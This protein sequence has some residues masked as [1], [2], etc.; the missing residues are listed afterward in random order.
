MLAA[1]P[2]GAIITAVGVL[3]AAL[4]TLWNTNEGFRDAVMAI[5]EAIKGFFVAAVEVIKAAWSGIT[6]FFSAV[7][8]GIKTAFSGVTEF[9]GGVFSAAWDAIK[10]VWSGVTA[11]SNSSFPWWLRYSAGSSRRH[12]MPLQP[13]GIQ[14]FRFSKACG[15]ASARYSLS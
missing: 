13:C 11:F 7:W 10:A 4:I 12:G 2:L 14:L 8:E 3:V 1:N 5:W 15:T 9:F 6:E